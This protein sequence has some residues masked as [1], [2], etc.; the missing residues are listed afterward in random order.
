MLLKELMELA[1]TETS[2]IKED[3]H[4]TQEQANTVSGHLA[5]LVG[6]VWGTV[7]REKAVS[8]NKQII[9]G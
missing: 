8:E 1:D 4:L 2:R 9:K 7:A 5:F 3:L 6:Q